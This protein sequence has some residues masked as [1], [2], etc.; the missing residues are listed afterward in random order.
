MAPR[1]CLDQ[2]GRS[3]RHPPLCVQVG[4]PW[5]HDFEMSEASDESPVIECVAPAPAATC[6]ELSPA[7]EY[8]APA[9]AVTCAIPAP[10]ID[11]ATPSPM[12]EYIK[13]APSVIKDT[14][15]EQFSPVYT[16]ESVTTGVRS[17][18]TGWVNW[19]CAVTPVAA[20]APQIVGSLPHLD[21]CA[22]LVHQEQID[23]PLNPLCMCQSL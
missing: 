2:D 23:V 10:V 7:I 5:I 13:P 1:A 8:V 22:A 17:D 11:D 16:M 12:I 4:V 18:T 3:V 20:S 6:A 15:S 19:Q 14:P 9:P 21:E